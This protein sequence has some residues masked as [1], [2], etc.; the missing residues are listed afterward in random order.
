MF[1]KGYGT[2][3]LFNAQTLAPRPLSEATEIHDTDFED[4]SEVEDNSPRMSIN[5]V[6][7]PKTEQPGSSLMVTDS[8]DRRAI[9][10]CR[11]TTRFRRQIQ[12]IML[13]STFSWVP[14]QWKV[15]ADLICSAHLKTP[16]PT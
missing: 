3:T 11:P 9:A 8:L 15:H 2:Q 16:T 4:D 10:P 7:L 5:S 6:G 12:I 13:H 14:N 1:Q